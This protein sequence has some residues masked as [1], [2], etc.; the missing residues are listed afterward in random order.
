MVPFGT[1]AGRTDDHRA[2]QSIG[3]PHAEHVAGRARQRLGDGRGGTRQAAAGTG[4]RDDSG[5]RASRGARRAWL[6][7]ARQAYLERFPDAAELFQFADFSVFLID[8]HAAR[9]VGG[10]AQAV[11]LTPEAFARAA[12]ALDAGDV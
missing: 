11:T 9:Y 2:R 4:P 8:V 3:G 1:G 12:A 5:T 6:P 7:R 10:F